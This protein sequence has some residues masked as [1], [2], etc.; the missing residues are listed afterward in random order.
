MAVRMISRPA[1]P[2]SLSL[3]A[4]DGVVLLHGIARRARS[5]AGLEHR[6]RSAGYATLNLDYP[7]RRTGLQEI[8]AG[9]HQ[10]I[11]RFADGLDGR[12]HF[13]T[14]SMGGLVARVYIAQHRPAPLGRVVML[15][16]P[17]KAR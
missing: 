12:L 7:A 1:R 13:V 10:P 15:A 16:P 17:K 3:A 5:L 11:A 14:H 4:M 9:L 8:A 6:L 2:I